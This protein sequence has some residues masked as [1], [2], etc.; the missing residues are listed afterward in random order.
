LVVLFFFLML[1]R[2]W[3]YHL[4]HIPN[5]F[6]LLVILWIESP[7]L[8]QDCDPSIYAP[9]IAGLIGVCHHTQLVCWDWVSWTFCLGCPQTWATVPPPTLFFFFCN[10]NVFHY[11]VSIRAYNVLQSYSPFR[12]ALSFPPSHYSP[13]SVF[14]RAEVS[15]FIEVWELSSFAYCFKW[16]SFAVILMGRVL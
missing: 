15:G 11:S 6:L 7:F 12:I 4:S 16:I 10:F 13:N 3:Q 1:A 5:H 8:C 9:H 14:W 2:Q